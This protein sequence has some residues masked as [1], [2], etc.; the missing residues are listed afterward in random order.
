MAAAPRPGGGIRCPSAAAVHTAAKLNV[1]TLDQLVTV[2][3]N[4]VPGG[5]LTTTFSRS[6]IPVNEE[7]FEPPTSWLLLV[8]GALPLSYSFSARLSGLSLFFP[9]M[10]VHQ[11]RHSHLCYG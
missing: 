7:G 10:L 8:P 11:Q 5:N 4:M 6:R 3:D 2:S 9:D 1:G